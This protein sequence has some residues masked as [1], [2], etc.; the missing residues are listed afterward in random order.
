MKRAVLS[1]AARLSYSFCDE[2]LLERALTHRSAARDHNERLE[3]LGD[4]ILGFLI[5]EVLL[6][7]FPEAS[8]GEL[9]RL[10][11]KLV[12]GPTLADVARKLGLGDYLKLGGGELKSGGRDRESIL[13]D[14]FEAVIGA[15]YLDGGI[16]ACRQS[17]LTIFQAQFDRISRKESSKDPKTCLQEVLQARGLSL[18]EYT[19]LQMDG[20][21]HAQHFT[22]EC[23]IEG[24]PETTQGCGRSRRRAEQEA[25]RK[26][27]HFF[28]YG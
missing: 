26:A 20:A 27:L 24:F 13:A 17:V 2:T 11:A 28:E 5:A 6:T 19:V 23:R 10:R 3:F 16:E 9:T 22:V 21:A 18:P 25:A 12:R 15:M 4:A 7:H 1:L 14:A 8:E